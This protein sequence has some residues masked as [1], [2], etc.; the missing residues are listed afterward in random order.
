MAAHALINTLKSKRPAFGAWLALPGVIAARTAAHASERLSW[1]CLDCEHGLIPLQPGAAE[2][3][4]AI[5]QPTPGGGE[6][7]SVLVRIPAT[8]GAGA[9]GMG[10]QI[11]YALD[12][13]ARGVI[14]PMVR[15]SLSACLYFT[16]FLKGEYT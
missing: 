5:N 4:Q 7:P 3:I 10:W 1:V 11:K 2:A 16:H 15:F 6:P 12:S 8:G 13:G 9:G 14:V